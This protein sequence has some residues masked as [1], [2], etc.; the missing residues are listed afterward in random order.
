MHDGPEQEARDKELAEVNWVKPSRWG[1]ADLGYQRKMLG[2]DSIADTTR[3]FE[4]WLSEDD[5]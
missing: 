2:F 5:R 4:V 1:W 3:A